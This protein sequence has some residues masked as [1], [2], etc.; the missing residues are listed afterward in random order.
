MEI[1]TIEN[2][3]RVICESSYYRWWQM[4]SPSFRE[5]LVQINKECGSQYDPT[6]NLVDGSPPVEE[7][8]CLIHGI[9]VTIIKSC[10]SKSLDFKTQMRGQTAR[11]DWSTNES[12][13]RDLFIPYF[14]TFLE[15]LRA[16]W[17]DQNGRS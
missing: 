13:L 12:D 11:I 14:Q 3:E 5:V 15:N 8:S 10:G 7:F 16:V 9:K 2:K 4:K 6:Y 17:Y 1:T